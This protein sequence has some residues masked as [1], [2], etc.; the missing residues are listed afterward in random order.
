MG[1]IKLKQGEG[2][3]FLRWLHSRLIVNNKNVL[4]AELGAT[5]S[6]KSYRDLRKAELWYYYHFNK[7]FPEENICFSVAQVIKL[8]SSGNLQRGEIIIFEEAGANLGSL[9]FQSKISKMFTYVLQSFRSMNIALFMN[10]PYLSMLNKQA[11]MLLHYV[12]ESRGVDI[13]NNINKCRP[14]FLQ[15]NQTSGKTYNHRP[16]IVNSEGKSVQMEIDAYFKPSQ[17]LIDAYE[18]KKEQFLMDLTADFTEKLD[19]QNN[20]GSGKEINTLEELEALAKR[21]LSYEQFKLWKLKVIEGLNQEEIC[22]KLKK[23]KSTISARLKVIKNKGIPLGLE[24][25]S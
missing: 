3:F 6:G 4:S 25:Y 1:L 9:D 7:K 15:I 2:Y 5:G 24:Q 11:R 23:A 18:V 21:K 17:Y 14:L 19:E 20:K 22:I 10:L 13:K 16:V 8:L 12:S